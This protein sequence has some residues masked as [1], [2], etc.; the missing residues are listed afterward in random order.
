MTTT[1]IPDVDVL[2]RPFKIRSLELANR[3]VMSP[4]TRTFSPGGV[5]GDDVAAHY[6]RRAEGGVGLI[7]SE[8][9]VIDR[10]AARNHPDIPL[11]HGDAALGGWQQV[12]SEV[13][14]AGGKMGPQLWHVGAVPGGG[15]LPPTP[16]ESPSGLLAP[17]TPRGVAMT[18]ED[19]ADAIAAFGRAAAD[20]KRLGFD[21]AE[22]H[23]AHGYLIDEFF[24]AGTNTRADR[25]GG[26]TLKERSRFATEVIRSVRAAS[27]LVPAIRT[28]A[29]KVAS[30]RS[31][32]AR[33]TAAMMRCL[34]LSS[35]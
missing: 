10:P 12:I 32:R 35:K 25:F 11:F 19:V 28:S 22:L 6:R 1:T 27:G 5:P 8:G 16:V 3:I 17:G 2:F 21:V 26:A 33:R 20:A 13:H 31:P 34:A 4:M 9:T 18:D 14:A 15:W 24:W 29:R 7:L 23:G 30:G